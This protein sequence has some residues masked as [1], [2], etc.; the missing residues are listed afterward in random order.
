MAYADEMTKEWSS[1]LAVNAGRWAK[2]HGG[3]PPPP[4]A[5]VPGSPFGKFVVK[6]GGYGWPSNPFTNRPMRVATDPGDFTYATSGSSF[7]LIAH[8]WDG[9]NYAAP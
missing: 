2:Q 5:M 6:Q 3:D 7:K 9:Q 1:Y 8:L 4:L